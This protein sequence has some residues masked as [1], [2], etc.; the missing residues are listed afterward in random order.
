MSNQKSTSPFAAYIDD[1]PKE[2][3]ITYGGKDI[4]V[5][6]RRL[7][8]AERLQLTAGQ[9]G[10]MGAGGANWEFDMGDQLSRNQT[11]VQLSLCDEAGDKVYKSLK[12]LREDPGD[13]TNALITVALEALSEFDADAG[14]S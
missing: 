10:S 1:T 11:L 2:K 13:L 3:T 6:F 5:L 14:K 4:P 8:G 7:T 12:Q 9:K